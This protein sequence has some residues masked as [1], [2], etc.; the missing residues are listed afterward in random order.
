MAASPF[1]CL[2]HSFLAPSLPSEHHLPN[3]APSSPQL[4]FLLLQ[5]NTKYPQSQIFSQSS[6]IAIKDQPWQTIHAAHI[7]RLRHGHLLRT[8]LPLGQRGLSGHRWED[9]HLW[10]SSRTLQWRSACTKRLSRSVVNQ[11]DRK[12][13]LT[14]GSLPSSPI[15][16]HRLLTPKPISPEPPSPQELQ[17]NPVSPL[18][19]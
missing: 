14:P 8:T 13:T 16:R 11:G 6:N 7:R 18:R 17:A 3:P 9:A 19:I 1:P 4:G 10:Y 12:T 15:P 2:T 5:G